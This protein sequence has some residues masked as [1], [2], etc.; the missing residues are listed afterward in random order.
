[1]K[2]LLFLSLLITGTTFSQSK[3]DLKAQVASYQQRLDSMN[4]VLEKTQRINDSLS[5]EIRQKENA[6]KTKQAALDKKT[7]ELEILNAQVESFK[8]SKQESP[9]PKFPKAPRNNP[10]SND[11]GNGSGDG[12][13]QLGTDNY[14]HLINDLDVSG[15]HSKESCTLA[16]RVNVG[17]NG[18][19][20]GAPAVIRERTTTSNEVLIKKVSALI[21]S[22]AKYS[23][24]KGIGNT[25]ETIFIRLKSD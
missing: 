3:K 4:L 14:R 2:T 10:F 1:M 5:S 9:S 11:G 16:F 12:G 23:S 25:E 6:L 17:K 13:S 22:Q 15:I 7:K 24:I 8:A 18:E 21:K 20:I 19:I